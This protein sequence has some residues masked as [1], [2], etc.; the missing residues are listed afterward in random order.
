MRRRLM[1]IWA[2]LRHALTPA[3][4]GA[5]GAVRT[6]AAV[7]TLIGLPVIGLLAG[8]PIAWIVAAVGVGLVM[9]IL[10]SAVYF[11]GEANPEFPRHDLNVKSLWYADLPDTAHETEARVVFLPVEFIN[12]EPN[13]PVILQFD[14]CWRRD[15]G[16]AFTVSH[17]RG[18]AIPDALPSPVRIERRTARKA[19]SCST[20]SSRSR[21]ST[22]TRW[23]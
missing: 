12:R 3:V 16:T 23:T 6:V 18:R 8:I 19:M 20:G 15:D 5:G 21:S 1:P 7:T 17:F 13:Q 11:Y 2:V 4:R 14:L 22:G 10:R 9:L